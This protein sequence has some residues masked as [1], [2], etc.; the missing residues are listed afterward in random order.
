[1]PRLPRTHFESLQKVPVFA[2]GPGLGGIPVVKRRHAFVKVHDRFVTKFGLGFFDAECQIAKLTP[3]P[4]RI[5]FGVRPRTSSAGGRAARGVAAAGPVG[6]VAFVAGPIARRMT[7]S[8]G[9]SVV[10]AAFV[11]ALVSVT[12]D[13]GARR[14]LAPTELPVGVMTAAV[15]AP[16]LLWLLTRQAR[17]GAL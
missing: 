12:A 3:Q 5:Q 8:P 11:G 1:M 13:L 17:T 2:P 16:Y 9:A 7:H 15:G 4:G 14:L 6:F 10:P